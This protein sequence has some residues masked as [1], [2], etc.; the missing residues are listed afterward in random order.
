[1]ED[2]VKLLV[3][4][5]GDERVKQ[6]IDLSEH[7]ETGLG[8]LARAF[9]IATTKRELIRVVQL[10]KELKIKYLIMGTG[11]KMALSEQGFE[12][13]VIKN[14]SDS[15]KIFGIKGKVSRAGI[16]IEEAFLEADSGTSIVRLCEYA[17]SQGLG[18][19]GLEGL[20]TIGGSIHVLPVLREKIHQVKVI[21]KSGTIKEKNLREI[22][23]ED[24]VLSVVFL[25]KAKK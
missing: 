11:S 25:L 21:T 4:D 12:G 8:G 10:C 17:Q 2:L 22:T 24:I 6:N 1:M 20:G 9:Y 18:L 14:R 23:R 16:G 15:V 5:L 7:M 19:G 3:R 13:L